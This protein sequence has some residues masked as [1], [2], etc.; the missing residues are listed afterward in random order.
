MQAASSSDLWSLFCGQSSPFWDCVQHILLASSLYQNR[1]F[2]FST[3]RDYRAVGVPSP[4]ATASKLS[5]GSFPSRGK[6][7][8]LHI[9]HSEDSCFLHLIKFSEYYI[10]GRRQFLL[11]LILYERNEI[12]QFSTMR[13]FTDF[14]MRW[15]L[16]L[17]ECYMY[18]TL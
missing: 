2:V 15:H 7:L 18:L 17:K 8:R 16:H 10:C 14:I 1:I 12:F 4:L 11:Q 3:Q 6:G 9:V 5:L 13:F